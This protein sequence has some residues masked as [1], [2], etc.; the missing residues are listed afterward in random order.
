MS[1]VEAGERPLARA[2][3]SGM[4]VRCV[5]HPQGQR[6][7]SRTPPVTGACASLWSSTTSR[8]ATRT[9]IRCDGAAAEASSIF[10]SSSVRTGPASTTVP[11]T[12]R[13]SPSESATSSG[14]G[15]G[16]G[17]ISPHHAPSRTHKTASGSHTIRCARHAAI[18]T[19]RSNHDK[20]CENQLRREPYPARHNNAR[21]Q[22]ATPHETTARQSSHACVAQGCVRR[23]AWG[24]NSKGEFGVKPIRNWEFRQC[25]P[26]HRRSA[27]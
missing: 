15:A 13:N 8:V 2:R 26:A 5:A 27:A 20:E 3:R 21:R 24:P 12:V 14:A 10:C 4:P 18:R 17:C 23:R 16:C 11:S 1:L 25:F 7:V 22:T 9:S 19:E 6:T